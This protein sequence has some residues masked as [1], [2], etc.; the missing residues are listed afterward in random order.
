[1]YVVSFSSSSTNQQSFTSKVR[2]VDWKAVDE[3][4]ARTII[5][6]VIPHFEPLDKGFEFAIVPLRVIPNALGLDC[7]RGNEP[8]ANTGMLA[9]NKI[10]IEYIIKK[11][12]EMITGMGGNKKA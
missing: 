6:E 11:A 9:M 2:S 3:R 12:N 1:M 10:S 8:H 7:F 4:N 5:E